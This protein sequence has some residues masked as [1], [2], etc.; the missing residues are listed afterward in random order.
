MKLSVITDE[1]SMDLAHALDVMSE[2]QVKSAELR[3][4]NNKNICD[5]PEDELKE[6]KNIL[7]DK[8]FS[9]S[10][11][12][13][14]LLKC[15]LRKGITGEV[16]RM[17]DAVERSYEQQIDLLKHCLYLTD[18]FDTNIIRVFSFWKRGEFT[19]EVEDEVVRTL[20]E[21]GEIAGK[22]G[23]ILGLEN[24]HDCY[25]GTGVETGRVLRRVNHPAVK[26][27][28]DAGNAFFA[29]E[30]PYPEGYEALKDNLVHVHVKDV[31]ELR[32]GSR[33][34][35]VVGEGQVDFKE[36][37]EALARTGY[38]GYISLETHYVPF[39]G[40]PEQ[41]SRLCLASLRH[42]VDGAVSGEL[43]V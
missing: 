18:Y 15:E 33:R 39:A 30:K 25:V 7:A 26:A 5:F 38:S 42:L 20:T 43:E 14:P 41:G 4:I 9:V 21:M 35:V 22:A 11:I 3:G 28:W 19:P 36:Q 37:I 12:A 32:D 6:V 17:H 24:E 2:Y 10:C 1:I 16:G 27:V 29:D 8:G 13:S 23:K 34:C 31:E 40:T